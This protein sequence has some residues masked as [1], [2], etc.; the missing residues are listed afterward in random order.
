VDRSHK[1]DARAFHRRAADRGSG[2][3][4]RLVAL[5]PRRAGAD[6]Q[7]RQRDAFG[8]L[9]RPRAGAAVGPTRSPAGTAQA[10]AEHWHRLAIGR[11]VDALVAGE[12][13]AWAGKEQIT[14]TWWEADLELDLKSGAIYGPNDRQ[15]PLATGLQLCCEG[16]RPVAVVLREQ[17]LAAGGPTLLIAQTVA[18]RRAALAQLEHRTAQLDFLAQWLVGIGRHMIAKGLRQVFGPAKPGPPRKPDAALRRR[19]KKA[20]ALAEAA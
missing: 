19:R 14:S 15:R 17:I 18:E 2:L 7:N 10:R 11:L 9:A 4:R 12:L 6:R 8:R 16:E 5:A 3:P 1:G 13:S 20:P